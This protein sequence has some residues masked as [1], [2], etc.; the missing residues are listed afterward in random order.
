MLEALKVQQDGM[1][2]HDMCTAR[3]LPPRSRSEACSVA[4]S[5]RWRLTWR[6]ACSTS[7]AR[8]CSDASSSSSST[9]AACARSCARIDIDA[10]WNAGSASAWAVLS[11]ASRTSSRSTACSRSTRPV[12]SSSIIDGMCKGRASATAAPVQARPKFDVL[13]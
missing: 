4:P 1:H 9:L 3:T 5:L 12:T 2:V 7:A 13:L 10:A 6:M 11:S 8:S